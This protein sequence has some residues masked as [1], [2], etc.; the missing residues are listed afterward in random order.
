MFSFLL[1]FGAAITVMLNGKAV[2]RQ[3]A[4]AVLDGGEIA[5]DLARQ[6][7]RHAAQ[8]T[9]DFED[10]FAQA[11]EERAAEKGESAARAQLAAE[12]RRLHAEIADV[13]SNLDTPNL[14]PG[15]PATTAEPLQFQ[16]ISRAQFQSLAGKL[17][18]LGV[19]V[20]GDSG[21]VSRSGITVSWVYSPA[22]GTL[23]IHFA[24]LPLYLPA[25][26]LTRR[27]QEIVLSS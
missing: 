5:A 1:G 20:Q 2:Q 6:A 25:Q 18:E 27:I 12:L 7:R 22:D 17:K 9:E 11:R 24:E 15:S 10:A 13:K 3:I 4:R 19:E 16:N 26:V 21:T 8:F 23:R 14:L